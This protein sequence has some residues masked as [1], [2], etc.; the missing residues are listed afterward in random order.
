MGAIV[1]INTKNLVTL[2]GVYDAVAQV[3]L[4]SETVAGVLLTAARATVANSAFTLAN[5]ASNGE[6]QG[7]LPVAVTALLTQGAKYIVEV[8]VNPGPD[9][10]VIDLDL[11]ANYYR[12]G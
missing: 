7:Y 1:S 4:N 2:S 3:Y 10:T 8:T 12:G 5:V 6:Y 11:P 9:Q